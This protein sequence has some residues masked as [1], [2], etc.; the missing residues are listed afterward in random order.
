[1]IAERFRQR[2]YRV[3]EHGQPADVAVIHTCSVTDHA[4][5]RCRQEIRKVRR[6]NPEAIVCAVGCYVQAEPDAVARIDAVDLI[7]GN[8]RK[9]D[10]AT[11]VEKVREG[12]APAEP[13]S[14]GVAGEGAQKPLLRMRGS[15][16]RI[17]AGLPDK[18]GSAGA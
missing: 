1:M 14:L 9:Y 5:A 11:L 6:R 2:G 8:D 7:V 15:G 13:P 3:V 12:E 10:L 4:D 17:A 16:A 18:H